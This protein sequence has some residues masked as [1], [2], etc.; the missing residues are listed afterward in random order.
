[1]KDESR[2][3]ILKGIP[4]VLKQM[5]KQV[6]KDRDF[7]KIHVELN[8]EMNK[9]IQQYMDE[10]ILPNLSSKVNDWFAIAKEELKN[11]KI[12]LE[13]IKEG[14]NS[15]LQEDRLQLHCDFKILAGL[16]AGY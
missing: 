7:R 5:S 12:F 11:A 13:E 8:E 1:M 4:K 10:V 3:E 16:A 14:F 15:M 2:K 9:Q 6:S